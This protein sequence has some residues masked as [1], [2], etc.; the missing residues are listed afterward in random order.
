MGFQID[1]IYPQFLWI[2]LWIAT[3]Y[4]HKLFLQHDAR[5]VLLNFSSTLSPPGD[6]KSQLHNDSFLN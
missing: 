4:E 6:S 1:Y 5:F 2:T 3:R